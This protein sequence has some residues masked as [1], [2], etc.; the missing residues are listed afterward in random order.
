MKLLSLGVV[1]LLVGL[2]CV[3][4]YWARQP[5][6]T[7]LDAIL[8]FCIWP[9]YGPFLLAK[10][11]EPASKTSNN[12][13]L[14]A[15]ERAAD[16][17][18]APFLPDLETSAQLGARLQAAKQRV[19]DIDRLLAQDTYDEAKT[20]QKQAELQARGD[21]QSARM[22]SQ[23]LNIIDQLKALRDRVALEI[24]Q[25]SELL[26]Q[27]QIQADVVRIAGMMDDDT[28]ELVDNLLI[29]IEGLEAFMNESPTAAFDLAL[30]GGHA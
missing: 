28:R 24:S 30:A 27:L 13:V 12:D 6:K 17:P 20:R 1:Y 18:L 2:G 14:T 11:P 10:P 21:E 26:I 9:L 5:D 25:I 15:I 22:L 23:R 16:S 7:I 29:R 8:L 19:A 3:A 4:G